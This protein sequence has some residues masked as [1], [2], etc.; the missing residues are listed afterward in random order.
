MASTQNE[1]APRLVVTGPAEM[2]GTILPLAAAELVIGH[3]ATA[4]IV[5]DDTY[6]SRRH[7]LLTVDE[8]GQVTI[9]DLNSTGGTYV[10]GERLAGGR[11]LREG[12]VVRLADLT[13]RFE[14]GRPGEATG[15]VPVVV[16]E[17]TTQGAETQLLVRPGG[18]GAGP[19][20]GGTGG[21][22]A[23]GQGGASSGGGESDTADSYSVAGTVASPALPGI[24]G[25][26]V[27]LVD[28]NVG[29]D[30]LT[31]STQTA[32]DGSY[33]FD[34][35]PVSAGYLER[36]RKT[37]PDWQVQVYSGDSYL[38]GSAVQYAAPAS[39][40]LHVTLAPGTA[41]LPSEYETLTGNLAAAYDGSLSDLQEGGGRTDIS[42]LANRTGWDARAVALAA[43]S[44]QFS[45]ITVRT[46]VPRADPAQTQVW[47]QPTASIPAEF[48]YALFRAGLPASQD[49]LF[50]ASPATASAIWQ[51]A[52]A[53][54]VIPAALAK[55]VPEMAARF[56]ALSAAR[57]LTA[58]PA[59]GVSTLGQMLVPALPAAA[60]QEQFASLLAQHQGD[61]DSLWPA[62]AQQFGTET[63]AHLQLLG[64]L[65]SL[66][67]N[68][69]P[70][71]TAL[72][73]AEANAPIQAVSD[74]ASRGY[75]QAS[76]WAPLIGDTVPPGMPGGTA[77]E[78]AAS[79]AELMAAQVRVSFPTAVLASQVTAGVLPVPG[80]ADLTGQVADF[81]T[82][83]SEF[84]VG[85]EPVA[86][87]LARTGTTAPA[88]EVVDAVQR[89]QRA[90][91]LSPD[92]T[93]MAV[94][95]RANLD[96]AFAVTRYDAAGF[97]RAFGGQLGTDQAGAIHQRARQIFATTLGVAVAYLGGRVTQFGNGTVPVLRGMDPQ[98]AP[99]G[100]P[101]TAY[102]TLEDLFGSMDYCNCSDCGSILSPAAY[103]VDL[104]N[105]LD[106]PAPAG[107]GDNPQDILLQRRPDLA[108]LPLTCPNTNTALPY[109]DIVNETLEYFVANGLSM[110]G[111]TG[112]DTGDT[113][114]SAEL[115]ASPQYVNNGAYDILQG[116]F[117]PP[118]LP[119]SRPL[120]LLRLQ[121]ASLGVALPDAMTVLRAGDQL[122]STASPVSYGWDDILM[123]RL[124]IS[125]DEYRLFTDPSLTLGDLYGLPD[126]TALELLQ[127]TSL[128]DFSRRLGVSYDDLAQIVATQFINPN[129][130]LIPRLTALGAPFATLQDLHDNLGTAASIAAQF[131]G[132]LPAGLDATQYGGATPDDYQAVVSWVTGPAVYPLIMDIITISNPSGNIS[133]CSGADL[134]FRY[135]QP[136][137]P[138]PADPGNLL[139]G[140]DFLKLIRFI[141]LW[142]KLAP[143]LGDADDSV[144]IAQTD[145]ILAA[146]YPAA[147][148]PAGTSS[149]ANDAAN[150]V[151]LDQGFA[152]LLPRTGFLFQ[153]LGLL[154]LTADT[155]LEKLLAC[156]AP[157]GTAG[158]SSL[159]QA[160][161][162]TPTL[163]QQDPG[164]QTATVSAIVNAGDQLS[165]SINGV[166]ISYTVTTA[167]LSAAGGAAAT[168]AAAM[169]AQINATTTTDPVS[170]Q[171]LNTRFHATSD[172]GVVTI[173]AGFAL[174]CAVSAGATES[175]AP[176]ASTPLS[177]TATV[178]G[179]VTPGDTL[180]TTL[181]G[182][183]VDYLVAPG[184]TPDSIAAGI[185]AAINGATTADPYSG[186]PLNGLLAASASS[187][188]VTVVA[189]NA[190]APFTLACSMTSAGAGGYT[191]AAPKPAAMT[192]TVSGI[193]DQG[194]VLVT[195][196]NSVP[197]SYTTG[198]G[199]TTPVIL[200]ASIA[201]A[202]RSAVQPDPATL[203]PLGEEVRAT[204]FGPVITITSV[205]PTAPV[206]VT[207]SVPTGGE[208]YTALGPSPETATAIVT[209][210]IPPGA[211]LTTTV[212]TLPLL[213]QVIPGDTPDSI[214]TAIAALVNTNPGNLIDP[215]TGLPLNSVVSASQAGGEL[216]FTAATP[217][218]PFTLAAALSAGGYTAGR[219]LPPF[220][221]D[222][223]GDYLTDPSQTLLGHEP[224]LCAA[225]N[226][227]GA[228]F[229]LI[230]GA[231]GFG[232]STPLTLANVSALFRYGWLAHALGLSVLEFLL[233][234]QFS[235]QDPF[236]PLDPAAVP[237]AQPPVIAFIALLTAL[238]GAGLDITAALYLMWN[239]DIS[240]DSAPSLADLTGLVLALTGDFAAVEAEFAISD[241]PD[242]TI[243]EGLM[244]LVYGAAA[245]GF[246]FGLLNATMTTSVSY[247]A[248]PGDPVLP[249][250]VTDAS[251]GR[252][253]YDDLRKQLSFGGVL[254]AAT[255]TAIDT[256]IPAGWPTLA[257]AIA[258][259]AAASQQ[260][261]A[262]FFTSYPEL[263]P[264][265]TAY[266][267]SGDAVQD[268]RNTLLASFLPILKDKRKQEQAQAA[269][270]SAA[271]TDPSFAAALLTAPAVLSADGDP[272]QPAITDL[273][274]VES[275]GL[276][277]AFFLGNDPAAAPDQQVDAV[278]Q[279]SYA[280]T[281]TIGG[282]VTAGDT[283]TLTINGIAIGYT[284]AATDTSLA[285]LA[286]SIAAAVGAATQ[287]DPVSSLPLNQV[288]SA[289]A[290]GAVL[291][292]AGLNPSG[293][294]GY[295]TVAC[296]VSAGATETFTAGTQLPASGTPIAATWSGYLT[297][298]QDGDYDINVVTDPGASVTLT[299]NG[300]AVPVAQAG[301]LWS[302]SAP[303]ALTAGE[304]L[305]VTLTATSL[306][307]TL[308]VSWESLGL[309]WQP[310]PAAY[311][312]PLSLVTRLGDTYVRFLKATSLA[313]A[314]SLTAA[315]V[316][317]LATAADLDPGWLNLL[318]AQG[319]PAPATASALAGVLTALLDFAAMKQA[320]SPSDE[321]LLAV[322]SDPGG[323]LP[324]GG[325][326]LLSLT[327]W[328]QVSV[329]AL[330][331]QFFGSTSPASLG[332]VV[333][334]RRVYDAYALVKTC[335]LTAASLIAAIT[336]APTATTVSALQSA[337]RAQYAESDWLTVV[338]PINDSARTQQRDALVAYV[339]QQLGDI[340]EQALV[341]QVT[342]AAA[343]TGATTVSCASA[344]GIAEGMTVQGA[345]IATGTVVAGV[346]GSTVTLSLPT[347]AA[348]PA[349]SPLIFVP[350]AAQAVS[351]ADSLYE[352]LLI[353]TQTEPPVLTSRMLLAISTTQLFI[354]RIA[355]NLEPQVS[356]LDVNPAQWEWMK[357]YRVWQANRE[358][359]LWPE[360]WLYPELR[361]D[362]S[363]LFQ[364]TMTGLLQGDI[365]NDAA[366][367]AYLGYLSGLEEVAKLEPC[368]HFYVPASAD[369]DETGYV[370]ARTAGAHRKY[371]FR[372]LAGGSWGPWTQVQIDCEDMPLTPIVWNGRLF[373]FWV[374]ALKQAAP[375]P[376]NTG[377]LSGTVANYQI[378]DMQSYAAA[379][380]QA[381]NTISVSATLCWAE[382]YNGAWQPTK[383]SD[384]NRPASLGSF[385]VTDPGTVES[386][387]NQIQIVPAQF[388][389]TNPEAIQ[390][391]VNT[392]QFAVPS[393][394]LLL[395]VMV[396]GSPAGGFMLHNTHS[397]PIIFDDVPLIG[398]STELV[399]TE[400]GTHS[401]QVPVGIPLAAVLDVPSP[402]RSFPAYWGAYTGGFAPS[403][404]S[405]SYQNSAI[406][407]PSY[408]NAL[409]EYQWAP[410]YLDTQPGL[411]GAW[412]APF[413]YEDRRNL[414]WV[415]TTTTMVPV[416]R[417]R[418]F[419][420]LSAAPTL[421]TAQRLTPPLLLTRPV[422]A[423]VPREVLAIAGSGGDPAALQR[424]L[425]ASPAISAALPGRQTVSYQGQVISPV[426]SLAALGPTVIASTGSGSGSTAS[427]GEDK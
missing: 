351:T 77:A 357:R 143:L 367:S 10:N 312:F 338:G 279:L 278:P 383:T 249:Q 165:T 5:L 299:L 325:S 160:M 13:A 94:L 302:N 329:N 150:R 264:L 50:Q 233:L 323:R 72:L 117:F 32:S 207:C 85:I 8:A 309:G 217:T 67:V 384:V 130:A 348:M 275:Q 128:Q 254:D 354:E 15:V 219:R 389:G 119:F 227:T 139:S 61:W 223:Y 324:S 107:G 133:D 127:T 360:N 371:Y 57:S 97:T 104:L 115:I 380:Q 60:Q 382:Y 388:T 169:A 6:V 134:Q 204:S 111:Y 225:C 418:A 26:T 263:V 196:V 185:A 409:L 58:P 138:N 214:A 283:L 11:I 377:S 147:D 346:S 245:S 347:L 106:Q 70:V 305:P 415:T 88:P 108:Y 29:G 171:P 177:A 282:T 66:T 178:G 46:S 103:L 218:T 151:L 286:A 342:S 424:L 413:I 120:T 298:P 68:S 420:V 285:V 175:Y 167:D 326:A 2:A 272:G 229:T 252:L 47:P 301:P 30:R 224:A 91:Q 55:D 194:D 318:A 221:D 370:I 350:A 262:P 289:T 136:P 321:R 74:L 208:G 37:A 385:P 292:V 276:S 63:T 237:P 53:G 394:A 317:Y 44:S 25:L 201:A 260:A 211:L 124:T 271:G 335:G 414:F 421:A 411:P 87:Y 300:D 417:Q 132:A 78:Q 146:L 328:A 213:Y 19:A 4:D 69:V 149:T 339:L 226:L 419:G 222:G 73:A 16:A 203:V 164:A 399:I 374:K 192:A 153:V 113:V 35:V 102:P 131:I 80:P 52:I 168:V 99:P 330:L 261:V 93:S 118:P 416:L 340:Y 422:T 244:T 183:G 423:A 327:G 392:S 315:E 48:Y 316:S 379:A 24:G 358:V 362:Q 280:P 307:T 191:A 18:G 366:V 320:L 187:A 297:A 267:A 403:T 378:G 349:G 265:Y 83:Q 408:S 238:S 54:N 200:A 190:G 159:Y 125:R 311:L 376:A 235:G 412:D 352:Y 105:Y 228:E 266:V 405:V 176:G 365:T 100:Y 158:T 75:Y 353:D 359:F 368:G 250:A 184:D 295:L 182:I 393:D 391:E 116:S 161:F 255:Q 236:A 290:D 410:R 322:L 174:A 98:Q 21:T 7:A 144:T 14:P 42:Y 84:E 95:L 277:A 333:S 1:A 49:T 36:L 215:V 241:D 62:V 206:T 23:A 89:L 343:A 96:S 86:A 163:L 397:L 17:A 20:A 212:N 361:D 337:L 308:S 140:T 71:V 22:A 402:Y 56:Q 251:S 65:Y 345:V 313:A 34:D 157:I 155:G 121:L 101:V 82:G 287:A 27:R 332:A 240:G 28:K 51:Q 331:T 141:R 172:G 406:S 109:I 40:T 294:Y 199:D 230:T 202:I 181:D 404:F 257:P 284:V 231:L 296:A 288:A 152:V 395:S 398:I 92:D 154:S 400:L 372:E 373:L 281:A 198:P 334:L 344:A 38:G 247:S 341:S 189:A 364:Q 426:G 259:L 45:E 258:S 243:A 81:L 210:S 162:L 126:A 170:G 179:T 64:Q 387:R 234:R 425:A 148:Q 356:A 314:L 270:T 79:Y 355:R 145:A 310:I 129:A 216:T 291:T 248:P 381:Q 407:I 41:G 239:Q 33:S 90:Y 186:L 375:Q 205:D 76:A 39:A 336:N 293:Q 9:R 269:I 319:S 306:L 209:G 122:T 137:G 112:H 427:D 110:A 273:T 268:K 188:T 135:S 156:W 3:S 142:Q 43:L 59:A 193:I 242:G 180:T 274:A 232:A 31:A 304:L 386:L 114:T 246:F 123:E 390:Y 256:A 303:I 396:A 220:A 253:G 197:V 173:M 195:T 166:A 369:T 401:Y 12:D 363:P